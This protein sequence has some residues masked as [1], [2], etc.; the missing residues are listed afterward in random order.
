MEVGIKG[1]SKDIIEAI[2][3]DLPVK[4]LELER[5][6]VE[7]CPLVGASSFQNALQIAREVN[8]ICLFI[9]IYF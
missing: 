2:T 6:K 9:V 4:S 1:S 5:L 7:N 8:C 3:T